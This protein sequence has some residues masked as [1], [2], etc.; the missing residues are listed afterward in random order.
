MRSMRKWSGWKFTLRFLIEVAYESSDI[1][2]DVGDQIQ[3]LPLEEHLD[4]EFNQTQ[5]SSRGSLKMDGLNTVLDQGSRNTE[6]LFL[7]VG[8]DKKSSLSDTCWSKWC[9][10]VSE[11]AS[12]A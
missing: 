8:E 3:H 7:S 5:F 2:A 9:S 6:C 4:A 11:S 1:N 10:E 12:A